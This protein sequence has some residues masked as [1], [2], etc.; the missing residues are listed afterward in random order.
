MHFGGPR[1]SKTPPKFN[2][3]T[4]RESTKSEIPGGKKKRAGVRRRGVRGTG[5]GAG[6][7]AGVRGWGSGGGVCLAEGLRRKG[8]PV[9][10]MKK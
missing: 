8:G 3:K 4:P 7:P 10:D 1:S 2:E 5:S 6:Y 9:E